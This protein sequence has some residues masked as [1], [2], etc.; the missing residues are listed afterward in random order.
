MTPA[1]IAA[2]HTLQR[3]ENLFMLSA[4]LL[5]THHYIKN[6]KTKKTQGCIQGGPKK[7]ATI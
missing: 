5:L 6:W 7:L 2:A 3:L 1:I 4:S